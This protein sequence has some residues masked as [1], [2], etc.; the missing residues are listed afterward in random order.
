MRAEVASLVR[1][2]K[3]R[4]D[5]VAHFVAKWG[6]QEPLARPIDRGFNRLAWALP[7]L[8]GLVG[9]VAVGGAAWRWSR[10]P[11]APTAAAAPEGPTALSAALDDELRDLD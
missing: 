10:R 11:D 2:G 8:V 3:S 9:V 5:V 7:Y 6:S 4:D 1:A